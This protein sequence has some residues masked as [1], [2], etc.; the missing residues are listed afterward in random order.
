MGRGRGGQGEAPHEVSEPRKFPAGLSCGVGVVGLMLVAVL[1]VKRAFLIDSVDPSLA[2]FDAGLAAQLESAL[3]LGR[4]P[5]TQRD[6]DYDGLEYVVLEDDLTVDDFAARLRTVPGWDVIVV[7]GPYDNGR[8]I[9]VDQAG[10]H[11]AWLRR[12][13]ERIEGWPND[14][15]FDVTVIRDDQVVSGF[16]VHQSGGWGSFTVRR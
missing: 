2:P 6:E 7:V 11:G 14:G 12:R 4:S 15:I 16:F 9:D 5:P 13:I 10:L 8:R 3:A 1:F